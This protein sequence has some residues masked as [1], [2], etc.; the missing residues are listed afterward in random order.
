MQDDRDAKGALAS[1]AQLSVG[2]WVGRGG[3][4]AAKTRR[5]R[6]TAARRG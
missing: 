5:A 3:C 1:L 6:S 2:R 4:I